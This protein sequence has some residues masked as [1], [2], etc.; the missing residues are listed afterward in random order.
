M[1]AGLPNWITPQ[2]LSVLQ[3]LHDT[4]ERERIPWMAA[5]GL[6]GNLWGST[7]P[8]HDI[9][10]D[11]PTAALSHLAALWAPSVTSYGRYVDEEF[12]LDLLRLRVRDV[13]VDISG[14]DAAY[15]FERN[16]TRRLLP[17]R[18]ARR[19]LRELAGMSIPCQRLEDLIAYKT[20]IGREADLRE[21]SALHA[22]AR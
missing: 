16:G 5:A 14:A 6:A 19:V 8:L 21:L 3:E 2:Q 12:D 9:D 1:V 11:V 4:L 7:W 17:N 22:Q 18:L 10:L 13:E 15:G 20:V